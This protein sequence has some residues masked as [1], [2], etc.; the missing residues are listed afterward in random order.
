MELATNSPTLD[1]LPAS[2]PII[3]VHTHT[4]NARYLPLEGILLGK[5]DTYP[6]ITTLITDGESKIISKALID[7]TALGP[8]GN[9][10]GIARSEGLASER[11]PGPHGLIVEIFLHLIDLGVKEGAWD[12]TKTHLEQLE[13]ITRIAEDMNASQRVAVRTAAHMMG[14]EES[15]GD[16]KQ[17]PGTVSGVVAAVRFLWMLT[18]SDAEMMEIFREMYKTVPK[19]GE[20]T[21]VSHMMDLAPVYDQIPDGQTLLDLP[22]QQVRRMEYFQGASSSNLL[23]FVAYCPY[24]I[25]NAMPSGGLEVVRDAILQHHARGVKFYPPSGYRPA[26]NHVRPRP[27]T[28]STTAPGRQWDRRYT[29]FGPDKDVALEAEV[30][31]MLEWC[32]DQDIPVF[33]HSGYGQFEARKGYGEYHSNPKFWRQFLE[34]HS[35][36]GKPCTLRLCL[37]HAGGE[38]FWFGTGTHADWGQCVF[39]LCT[40]YPNVYCEITTSEKMVMAKSQAYFVEQMTRLFKESNASAMSADP[41]HPRYPFCKKLMYGTDWYLPSQGEPS[42][43]LLSTQRAFLSCGLRDAY[44]D[45]FSGNASRFLKLEPAAATR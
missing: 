21:L 41:L 45:Y 32:M 42:A 29:A 19:K 26:D 16:D 4:F 8:A 12:P 9:Q 2:I 7:Q 23:Y 34:K 25:P 36:P 35:C 17:G 31:R 13:V 28:L 38:D 14:M 6:P 10:P 5:R 18:Q 24:R 43:V 15:S 1:P 30:N 11:N 37:G 33:V 3:D 27:Y 22:S 40:H 39:D 44:A 20:I